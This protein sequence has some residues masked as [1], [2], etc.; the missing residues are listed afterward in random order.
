MHFL[1]PNQQRQSTEGTHVGFRAHVKIASRIVSY[2]TDAGF[3]GT[4][5]WPARILL[6]GTHA[7]MAAATSLQRSASGRTK[8]PA[9]MT[10][11]VTSLQTSFGAELIIAPRVYVV[12]AR[13]ASSADMTALRS[14]IADMK[15]FFC[16]VTLDHRVSLRSVP[17]HLRK[18]RYDTI[19]YEMLFNVRSK[20]DI[21]RLNLPHGNDN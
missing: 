3:A 5:L 21:S 17:I 15:Q 13:Q 9:N 7:D 11:L 18:L 6:V 10:S 2:R 19:R 12:D 4:Q 20:A 8:E 16:Q 14:V 1:P